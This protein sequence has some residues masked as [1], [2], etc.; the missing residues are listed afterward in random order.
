MYDD[1]YTC[2]CMMMMMMY[3]SIGYMQCDENHGAVGMK[4]RG[5]IVE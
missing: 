2:S 1:P 3:V 4:T 5:E